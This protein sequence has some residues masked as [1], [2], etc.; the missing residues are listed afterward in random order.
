M[1]F[2]DM[3]F[4]I[5]L[6]IGTQQIFGGIKKLSSLVDGLPGPLQQLGVVG[7]AAGVT[8]GSQYIPG[9]DQIISMAD[10][11]LGASISAATAFGVHRPSRLREK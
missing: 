5:L 11:A 2:L 8:W 6:G 4:P 3:L 1:G 10:P 7:I 9:L